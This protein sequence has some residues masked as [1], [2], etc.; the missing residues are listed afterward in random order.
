MKT[1]L[2]LT[3]MAAKVEAQIAEKRDYVVRSSAVEMTDSGELLVDTDD[4]VLQLGVTETMHHQ[5]AQATGIHGQYYRKMRKSAPELIAVN[6]NHWLQ[7]QG[8]RTHVL[9]TMGDQ[10][11]AFL[12]GVWRW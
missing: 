4:E 10:A 8:D 3:Q 9:R 1:G 6:V 5:L 11:R 7:K 2:T 12:G